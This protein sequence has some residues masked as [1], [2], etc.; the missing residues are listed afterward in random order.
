MELLPIQL[1][2]ELTG[3]TLTVG[4]AYFLL[5][6]MRGSSDL[7]KVNVATPICINKN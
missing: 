1:D 3:G 4:Y 5:N 7:Y 6:I 2:N